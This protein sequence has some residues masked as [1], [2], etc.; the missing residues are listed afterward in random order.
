MVMEGSR[1]QLATNRA[2]EASVQS[3]RRFPFSFL[4]PGRE[5]E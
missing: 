1:V 5:E 4:S 3:P 2:R